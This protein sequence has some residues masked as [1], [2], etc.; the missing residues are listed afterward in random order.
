[1]ESLHKTSGAVVFAFLILHLTN[2]LVGL[3]GMDAALQFMDAV[4]LV[5]RHPVV[6]MGLFLALTLQIITGYALCRDIW[7]ERKDIIHQLQ[8]ASGIYMAVFMIVHVAMIGVARYVFNL[9]TNAYFIAAQF[10]VWPWQYVAYGFYGLAIM[11]LFTHMGCI[12]F[13]IF[14][15]KNRPAAWVMLLLVV[16]IGGYVTWLL[17]AMYGGYLYGIEVPEEYS[18]FGI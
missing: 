18:R 13:D 16:G 2:H 9:D 17:M 6:E 14:K 15:K 5:Y 4:R 8:A 1:M 7:T 11:A 12:T 10:Q 3:L